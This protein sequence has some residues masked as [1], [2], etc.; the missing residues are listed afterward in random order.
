MSGGGTGG[1]IIPNLALIRELKMR[2]AEPGQLQL[3]YIGTRSGMEEMLLKE[4]A[5]EYRGI[6][7]GKLRRYFS[8]YNFL[9]LFKVPVGI[10]Q[11]FFILLRFSP[12]AVFC[13]GG[14]V[15]FPVAVAARL[16]GIPVVLHESDVVPGLANRLSARFASRICISFEESRKFFKHEK[17]VF[18]GNPVRR[19]LE[20]S[21]KAEGLK[22]LEFDDSLPVVLFM[23]GSLGADYINRLVWKNLEYLLPHYQIVHICGAGKVRDT[24]ELLPFLKEE[25]RRKISRYRAF[26]F[27]KNELKDVYAASDVIIG[28]AGAISLAEIDFFEKPAILI[29]LTKGASRGDQIVN[30]RAFA[31]TH[32]CSI[33]EEGTFSDMQFM[34][35]IQHFVKHKGAAH[36]G[37]M[38]QKD[39]FFALEK[40]IHILET[41]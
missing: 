37:H 30:A 5:V 13:K 11:A 6:T 15:C 35:E 7:C 14:Y 19:E 24:E 39:R 2:Y 36:F 38:K 28:R 16:L 32:V 21:N 33:L 9:D 34:E 3:L 25:H 4:E 22:F 8:F 1:H 20:F 31:K 12:N 18:T 10:V 40:I 41:V 29:P 27:I 26:E 17:V 23:G